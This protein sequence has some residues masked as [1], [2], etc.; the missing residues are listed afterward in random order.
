MEGKRDGDN[1][2]GGGSGGRGGSRGGDDGGGRFWSGKKV[3]GP[4]SPLQGA[5]VSSLGGENA[6]LFRLKGMKMTLIPPPPSK[7]PLELQ[8][9]QP[10]HHGSEQHDARTSYHL[11]ALE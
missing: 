6:F 9:P 1:D 7:V 5:N 10:P 3:I 2:G 11:Q 8:P 4:L